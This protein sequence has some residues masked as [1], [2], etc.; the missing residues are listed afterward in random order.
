MPWRTGSIAINGKNM[1]GFM[2]LPLP[3]LALTLRRGLSTP[4]CA[5]TCTD[6]P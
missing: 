4:A 5:Q 2:S 6:S 3:L 1:S